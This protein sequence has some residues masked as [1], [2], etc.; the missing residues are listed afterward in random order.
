MQAGAAWLLVAMMVSPMLLSLPAGAVADRMGKRSVILAMKWLELALLLAGSSLLYLRPSGGL[1]ALAVLFLLGVQVVL[2][3]P[4]KDG[5]LPGSCRTNGSPPVTACS[6]W[7]GISPS[8]RVSSAGESSSRSS[9][10]GPG[11]ED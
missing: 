3:S 8:S 2:L 5:I 10:G 4:A 6:S 9:V 1:P 11:W 7:G